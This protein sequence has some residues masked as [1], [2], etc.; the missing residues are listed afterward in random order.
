MRNIYSY[1]FFLGIFL[2]TSNIVRAQIRGTNSLIISDGG[3]YVSDAPIDWNRKTSHFQLFYPSNVLNIPKG[4]SIQGVSFRYSTS[5]EDLGEGGDIKIRLNE[6]TDGFEDITGLKDNQAFQICYAGAHLLKKTDGYQDVSYTFSTPFTYNGD[7]LIIDVSN[8]DSPREKQT[9]NLRFRLSNMISDAWYYSDENTY[10]RTGI[11]DIIIQYTYNGSAPIL[12]IPFSSRSLNF[13]VIPVNETKTLSVPA[14]NGGNQQ[15]NVKAQSGV[16]SLKEAS[17]AASSNDNLSV[18]FNPTKKGSFKEIMTVQSDGGV[19][20]LSLVGTTYRPNKAQNTAVLS[21]DKSLQNYNFNSSIEELSISGE[22]TEN[23]WRYLNQHFLKLRYL[24]LSEVIYYADDFPSRTYTTCNLNT[25]ERLSLPMNIKDVRDEA[26]FSRLIQLQQIILP[27]A[28]RGFSSSLNSC[29]LLTSIISLAPDAPSVNSDYISNIQTVYVPESSIEAYKKQYPYY[30]KKVEVIDDDILNGVKKK[31]TSLDFI[32]DDNYSLSLIDYHQEKKHTQLFFPKEM[33]NLPVGTTIDALTFYYSIH[34]NGQINV[35]NGHFNISITEIDEGF[36]ITEA[37]QSSKFTSF[38]GGSDL[39]DFSNEAVQTINY[40]GTPFT[41]NGKCLVLD[42]V[43]TP[44]SQLGQDAY[45]WISCLGNDFENLTCLMISDEHSYPIDQKPNISFSFTTNKE[46]P[47]LFVGGNMQNLDVGYAPVNGSSAISYLPV[48]NLGTSNLTIS[49]LSNNNQFRLNAP[50][51]IPAYSIGLVGIVFE[52]NS[53]G[54]INEKVKLVSNGGETILRLSGT[55]YRQV[56]Y[57]HDVTVS[58]D[59]DLNQYFSEHQLNRD[60]I[61]ALSITGTLSNNDWSLITYNLPALRYLD[62]ST[63]TIPMSFDSYS[64][65]YPEKLERIALPLNIQKRPDFNRFNNLRYLIYPSSTK[66]FYFDAFSN[67]SYLTSIILFAS[68]PPRVYNNNQSNDIATIYVP[69][70]SVEKYEQQSNWTYNGSS[71]NRREILPITD[72]ILGGDLLPSN[73]V[74]KITNDRVYTSGNYPKGSP[75]IQ[76][77]PTYT[78]SSSTASL[79]IEENTPIQVDTLLLSYDLGYCSWESDHSAYSSFINNSTE[80][81]LNKVLLHYK[82]SESQTWRFLTFP[83]DVN[84]SDIRINKDSHASFVFRRYDGN[85]RANNGV[86]Y[87]WEEGYNGGNWINLDARDILYSK[88]G[89][90]FQSNDVIDSLLFISVDQKVGQQF[91]EYNNSD[92]EIPLEN[93]QSVN[94]VDKSWNLTGN[95]YS[96]FFNL[97]YMEYPAPIIVWDNG[98]YIALSTRDDDYALRPLEAFFTQK[99]DEVS[100]IVFRKEGRQ[101]NGMIQQTFTSLRSSSSRQVFNLRLNQGEFTDRSRVVFNPDAKLSYELNCDA[102]KMRSSNLQMPQLYSL[103]QSGV[104]Y[105]INERPVDKGVVLLG[106]YVGTEETYT[107][108][109]G[110]SSN[111]QT[112]ILYDKKLNKQT[113]LSQTDYTF[114][115]EQGTFNDRF[116]LRL[117]SATS[118]D[119]IIDKSYLVYAAAG[120]LVVEAPVNTEVSIYTVSGILLHREN[121]HETIWQYPLKAGIYFIR[122]GKN[123][124]KVVIH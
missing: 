98:N 2:F 94:E 102:F 122:T 75:N 110:A 104:E 36:D 12:Y 32:G 31:I 59:Y 74:I 71:T 51:I 30:N 20:K 118:T 97:R 27:V 58:E 49:A 89:Y 62:L 95:P 53:K 80:A 38:Y 67:C 1:L 108:S 61:T 34:N 15:L 81:K 48:Q 84:L 121:M 69:E 72:D 65:R 8:E 26:F 123:S 46:D 114:H 47:I 50:V 64:F 103:D 63:A 83:F 14:Y 115:S 42:I 39:L 79:Q 78:T 11:P 107:L 82:V 88:I 35:E 57:W 23:D 66:E 41:Y 33:L 106:F 22:M 109:L 119:I 124:H 77:S 9:S 96:S 70:T 6:T 85:E 56:P 4:A 55:T 24:D 10:V 99:P 113:D 25:L 87:S 93:H 43:S 52:P 21:K 92:Q 73:N 13:G 68:T 28:L 60:T 111:V 86:K 5:T 105:A 117:S 76:L 54:F 101:I 17:I 120:N 100:S 112:I 44:S 18:L 45:C 7:C 16:F 91:L 40:K 29:K 37:V 90:I 3:N 19:A 116:E